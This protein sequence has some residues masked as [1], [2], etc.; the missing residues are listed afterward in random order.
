MRFFFLGSMPFLGAKFAIAV[1]PSEK[2]TVG[3]SCTTGTTSI[4]TG[5][6][7]V[8]TISAPTLIGSAVAGSCILTG[9]SLTN[10]PAFK[11]SAISW[12]LGLRPFTVS[13]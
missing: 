5:L 3:K 12:T 11:A 1:C 2:A 6:V 7:L 9:F 4:G 13:K 8:S 10:S